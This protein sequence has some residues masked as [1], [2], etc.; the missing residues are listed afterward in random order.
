MMYMDDIV[1]SVS[2]MV[3]DSDEKISNLNQHFYKIEDSWSR[4]MLTLLNI[5]SKE[6]LKYENLSI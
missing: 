1:G 4:S 2:F 3:Y 6:C 5:S